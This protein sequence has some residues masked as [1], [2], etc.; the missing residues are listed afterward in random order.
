MNNVYGDFVN[1][2]FNLVIW[3]QWTPLYFNMTT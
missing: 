1:L 2:A 3:L